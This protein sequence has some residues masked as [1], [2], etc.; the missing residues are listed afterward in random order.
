MTIFGPIYEKTE[1]STRPPVKNAIQSPIG[2]LLNDKIIVHSI[3]SPVLSI[4]II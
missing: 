3:A 4:T 2:A 1:N